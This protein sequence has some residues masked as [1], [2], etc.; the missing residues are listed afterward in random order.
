MWSLCACASAPLSGRATYGPVRT[1]KQIPVGKGP[2][3]VS[4]LK[5]QKAL[6]IECSRYK[7]SG[8]PCRAARVTSFA[9]PAPISKAIDGPKTVGSNHDV[10]GISTCEDGMGENH[11]PRL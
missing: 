3:S 5:C 6:R 9:A 10:F 1:R 11:T 2:I 7:V 4:Y 8:C